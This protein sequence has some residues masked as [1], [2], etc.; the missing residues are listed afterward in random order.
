[1]VKLII[2]KIGGTENISAI[3]QRRGINLH[4]IGTH[5]IRKGASTYSTSGSTQCPGST[6]V[7]LRAGWTLGGVQ[8]R[9]LRYEGAGDQ[10]VGRTVAGLNILSE[11]FAVLPPHFQ[12]VYNDY[13]F[14]ALNILM[15]GHAEY[16][17]MGAEMALASVVYHKD[18][19]KNNL[20]SRHPVFNTILFCQTNLMNGLYE[21]L[22]TEE[23]LMQPTG[24]I[25]FYL[26]LGVPPHV[27]FYR[28]M[29]LLN[30]IAERNRNDLDEKINN[31]Q[32]NIITEIA[33]I[34]RDIAVPPSHITTNNMESMFLNCLERLGIAGAL[35][36]SQ[37]V[38]NEI[39][40][41]V[42]IQTADIVNN[43]EMF[44]RPIPRNYR[45]PVRESPRQ[46]WFLW[47]KGTNL[48]NVT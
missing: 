20:Q 18:W 38:Q 30:I 17:P 29:E 8:D 45:F 22:Q 4:D 35:Q 47:H 5:S 44:R 37:T 21:K 3:Y 41:P 25:I 32:S 23:S 36:Q 48:L 31:M 6:A 46:M 14:D 39:V 26:M 9:Y 28:K 40:E 15:P 33:N 12:S 43:W 42:V 10:F 11:D 27:G 13:I 2:L 1:M 19:I 24:D 34:V 7:H 16:L